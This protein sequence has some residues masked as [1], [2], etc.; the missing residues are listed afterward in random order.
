MNWEI[1]NIKL[2]P[3]NIDMSSELSVSIILLLY[4]GL[5]DLIVSIEHLSA[6]IVTWKKLL[7]KIRYVFLVKKKKV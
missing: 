4:L 2:I 5:L 6:R 7:R 3:G 1:F